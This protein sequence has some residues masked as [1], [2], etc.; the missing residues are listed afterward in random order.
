MPDPRPAG[1]A[2]EAP[3]AE[4]T[5]GG[6]REALREVGLPRV[7]IG[8][9][10]VALLGVAWATHMNMP[11]L[12]GDCVL[13]I[14]R[15]GL[16][17]LALYPAIQGGLGLN[18]GLP[19]G[20]LCGLLGCVVTMEYNLG[21][22]LGLGTAA[23]IGAG[24]AIPAGIAYGAL[25]NRTRGQEMMVGTYLGFAVVSGMS[26]FWTLAPFRNPSLVWAISGRGLR[27]TL[28]LTGL[29]D[30][31]IDKLGQFT[32]AGVTIPTG[33]LILF[34]LACMLVGLFFRT[35]AGVAVAAARSNPRFALAAGI[36]DTRTRLVASAF[37]TALAAVGIVV[38][39]QS[40]GFVQ[41]YVA[42][43]YMAFPAV[44]CL[45]IGGGSVQR[46][47]LAHVVI[48]T[49]LFQS[50]LTVALPV[51]SQVVQ[52]DISDTARLIIQNG[53]ILYA[54]TRRSRS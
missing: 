26:I 50:I 4:T 39:S 17:V 11:S 12:L 52:G 14:G 47:T 28:T 43:L 51:T 1:V 29:Y 31:L 18:F 8:A 10:F 32:I 49:V 20:I 15:N 22:W 2:G 7:L 54:L 24:L 6:I 19:I 42:P 9:F 25:L 16:L 41:L 36:R 27:T 37:S 23:A 48:G 21:G 3:A 38:F 44:A 30:G 46:A 40:Y 34:A 33:T 13:R 53:M 35:R 45:L 5:P